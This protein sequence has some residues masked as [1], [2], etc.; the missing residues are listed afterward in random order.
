MFRSAL[1]SAAPRSAR[2]VRATTARRWASTS[3]HGG[4]KSSDAT[5]AM[6]SAVVFG[7][8]AAYLLMAGG[9]SAP[10][11]QAVH[12]G[13]TH[14]KE[15]H[16]ETNESSVPAGA[17]TATSAYKV[18][19]S[20]ASKEGTTQEKDA[21]PGVDDSEEPVS[22]SSTQSS[23]SG[24]SEPMEAADEGRKAEDIPSK[25]IEDSLHQAEVRFAFSYGRHPK[26][27]TVL[28]RV[29]P[30][31]QS[32]AVPRAAMSSESKGEGGGE[33]SS[34]SSSSSSGEVASGTMEAADEGRYAEDIPA[35]EIEDSLHQA[36][37]V[38][39]PRAAMDA[40]VSGKSIEDRD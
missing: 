17:K 32:V 10:A 30:L 12:K 8:T 1:R 20:V 23:S 31:L 3:G 13:T 21:V 36:E 7:A 9:D 11:H 6:G 4:S 24:S 39:V 35:K 14:M 15:F 16:D 5:W 26:F 28:L 19:K 38:G 34:S 18:D 27:L 37:A 33:H 22:G 25:E 40:E 2:S 29:T